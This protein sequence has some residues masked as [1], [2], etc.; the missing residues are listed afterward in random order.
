MKLL[1][2]SVVSDHHCIVSTIDIN[3][4]YLHS[5]LDTPAYMWVPRRYI[6]QPS[7][8]RLQ[9]NDRPNDSKV[10]FQVNNAIYGMDDAGR[11]SQQDLI[12]K[13]LAPYGFYICRHTPGLFRHRT[14]R[15]IVFS[16]WVDDFLVKSNPK[17]GDLQYL[18]DCLRKKYP[19]KFNLV[20]T[21]YIGYR[22]NLYRDADPRLDTLTID[23]PDYVKT[24]LA[25]LTFLV[26][27]YSPNS[28]IV[29]EAPVMGA[30]I[31]YETVDDTPP[32]SAEQQS[33]LRTRSKN[34]KS[35]RRVRTRGLAT[36]IQDH[37]KTENRRKR[38]TSSFYT[39]AGGLRDS[40][41]KWK[42]QK[43]V[44]NM[45]RRRKRRRISISCKL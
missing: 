35:D 16:V 9:L 11:V 44:V 3:D 38:H 18:L 43:T 4:F 30:S 14:R 33:F 34:L 41:S 22:I 7:R 27:S 40:G 37:E 42:K 36:P 28:P 21:S 13:L 10:L 31:Q 24:G 6:P 45:K 5:K 39:R 19:I 17:T 12:S 15:S 20:A 1:L 26:R 8:D 2:N 32:A 23:M 29:Y 25:S